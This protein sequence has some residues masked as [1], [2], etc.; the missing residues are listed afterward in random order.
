MTKLIHNPSQRYNLQLKNIYFMNEKKN[1][2]FEKNKNCIGSRVPGNCYGYQSVL[3]LYVV[4]VTYQF[5]DIVVSCQHLG[6]VHGS[7]GTD[8]VLRHIEVD[9]PGVHLQ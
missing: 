3:Y 6:Q 5:Y 2:K 7:Q 8:V 9:H 4:M 1:L